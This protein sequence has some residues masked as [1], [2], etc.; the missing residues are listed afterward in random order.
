MFLRQVGR[1]RR[2]VYAKDLKNKEVDLKKEC[3]N[4]LMGHVTRLE[5]TIKSMHEQG[6]QQ[7]AAFTNKVS[8][9][10]STSAYP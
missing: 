7:L 4:L 2:P 6:R 8:Q 9:T 3:Q 1:M 10:A 5:E